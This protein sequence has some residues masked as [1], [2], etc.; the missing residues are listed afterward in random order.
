M[1]FIKDGIKYRFSSKYEIFNNPYGI[2]LQMKKDINQNLQDSIEFLKKSYIEINGDKQIS[3]FEISNSANIAPDKFKA[4][5]WNRISSIKEYAKE[6]GFDTPIFITLTPPSHLKPLKQIKLKNSIKL[7]DNPKFSGECDYVIK[8]RDFIGEAWR[9][10]LRQAIFRNIKAKYKL[11]IIYLKTYEPF[12]DGSAHCHIVVFIPNEFK[13]RFTNLVK[14]YFKTRTDIK[15]EFKG[16]IGGVVSYLLKYVLKTFKNSKSNELTDTA[17]WYIYYKIR[18]FSTSRTLIPLKIFH[19]I[20]HKEEYRN[21]K[22]MTHKY[23]GGLINMSLLA[24]NMKL[25]Y[26]APRLYSNDY[27]ICEIIIVEADEEMIATYKIAYQKNFDVKL[28]LWDKRE[29][30]REFRV[31]DKP[32]INIEKLQNRKVIIKNHW[33]QKFFSEMNDYELISYYTSFN[34]S[35]DALFHP[36]TLAVLENEFI[37]RNLSSFTGEDSLHD[38]NTNPDEL[39]IYFC[40]KY[41]DKLPNS[42]KNHTAL[43]EA[44]EN[45]GDV[46]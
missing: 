16:D 17:Y 36:V 30:H 41:S 13:D 38:L 3:L 46:F 19:K 27:K 31:K 44:Y 21:L 8:S 29:K 33:S 14:R 12:L 34:H 1:V 45:L 18:R 22:E 37:T 24:N 4:E 25:F 15:T 28:F 43:L 6:I 35:Y 7:I 32:K 26:G 5:L 9:K 11:P 40:K 42:Y 20:K 39:R 2:S 10:F 23:Y